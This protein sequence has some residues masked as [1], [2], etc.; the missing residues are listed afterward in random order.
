VYLDV[1]MSAA[2]REGVAGPIAVEEYSVPQSLIADQVSTGQL[3]LDPIDETR[4]AYSFFARP[5][6]GGESAAWALHAQ[7]RIGTAAPAAAT[8]PIDEARLAAEF[9]QQTSGENYYT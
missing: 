3:A 5:Q 9:A 8:A 7:G 6:S 2:R 1:A 4:Y